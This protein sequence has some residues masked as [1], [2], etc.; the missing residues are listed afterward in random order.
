ME[1]TDELLYGFGNGQL[2][3]SNRREGHLFRC[4]IRAAVLSGGGDALS[5]HVYP[6]WGAEAN[7]H[8]EWER[9]D[10][11]TVVLGLRSYTPRE[12]EEPGTIALYGYFGGGIAT[13]YPPSSNSL[14]DPDRIKG[15]Y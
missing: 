8:G 6:R 12:G 7:E 13:L 5:V 4:E 10:T 14:I 11:G 9:V 1:L 3:I 15:L 2:E